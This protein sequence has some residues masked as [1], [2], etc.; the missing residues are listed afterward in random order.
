[1]RR[2]RTSKRDYFTYVLG[3]LISGLIAL[4]CTQ[5]TVKD[6]ERHTTPGTPTCVE[7]TVGNRICRR[8]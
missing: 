8:P 6:A 2:V 4:Q 3:F 7:D 5:P 1:M